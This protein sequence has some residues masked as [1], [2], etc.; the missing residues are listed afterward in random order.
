MSMGLQDID[1]S[2]WAQL[3][4]AGR[5]PNS[6]FR[7]VNFCSVDAQSRP[8]ARMVVLRCADKLA[9]KLE[10]H[11]DARSPKWL[12]ISANPNV[13][14]LGYCHQTRLQLRLTGTVEL[15]APESQVAE[16]A[17]SKLSP[18]TQNTYAAGPPGDE[19]AFDAAD[20]NA[21]PAPSVTA[22]GKANFGVLIVKVSMLDWYQLKRENNQRALLTYTDS[23]I[24]ASSQWI[25]P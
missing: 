10:F 21:E 2:S 15:H 13:T 25:N 20:K 8:Q 22:D 11:T 16:K 9:R 1:S 3:E 12:E 24:C 17:W 18:H 6:A 19:L 5:C 23:G 4:V 14:I 7:Y